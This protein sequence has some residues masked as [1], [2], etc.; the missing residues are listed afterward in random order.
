MELQREHAAGMNLCHQ[1]MRQ[2]ARM[3]TLELEP[4]AERY[5]IT[6]DWSITTNYR[7]GGGYDSAHYWIRCV[8][9][10]RNIDRMLASGRDPVEVVRR[11]TNE[12]NNMDFAAGSS[13]GTAAAPAN[14]QGA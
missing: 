4:V 13:S 10:D 14:S 1:T 7:I 9:I 6:L 3:M 11:A 5:G 8:S 2:F 12:L